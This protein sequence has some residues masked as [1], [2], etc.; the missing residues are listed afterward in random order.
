MEEGRGFGIGR[1]VMVDARY[2]AGSHGHPAKDDQP[3][4]LRRDGGDLRET[5]A[6]EHA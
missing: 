6:I 1:A 5:E 4:I 3:K 2:L